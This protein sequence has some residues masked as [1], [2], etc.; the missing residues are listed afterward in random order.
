M[1]DKA[2]PIRPEDAELERTLER[3]LAS[4]LEPETLRLARVR[5]A[6]L[7]SYGATVEPV[8]RPPTRSW[9]RGWT[10][11]AAFA[12]LLVGGAGVVAADGGPG[13][14][15]Y[16]IR[17]AI[18]TL[19]LPSEAAARDRGLAGELDDRLTEARTAS[20]KGD[21]AAMR[22]ALDA[23]RRTLRELTRSVIDDPSII[24]RLLRQQ[25]LLQ[26]LVGTASGASQEGLRQALR[27][28]QNAAAT[29][30]RSNPSPG[31]KAT[32]AGNPHGSS[33]PSHRP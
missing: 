20:R 3:Q 25:D 28:A 6:V 5:A 22:A 26:A 12:T 32:P 30:P 14:P 24:S 8:R 2:S 16:E 18:G 4:A 13:Q 7:I 11:A 23:Y 1:N 33:P 17:L 9:L 19:L 10:V 31:P 29:T 15:F 27:E 21:A